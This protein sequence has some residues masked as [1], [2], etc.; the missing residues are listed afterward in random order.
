VLSYR[1]RLS[2]RTKTAKLSITDSAWKGYPMKPSEFVANLLRR[3][4]GAADSERLV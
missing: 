4:D 2:A 1:G 3:D